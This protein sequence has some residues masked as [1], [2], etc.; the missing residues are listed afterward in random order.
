MLRVKFPIHRAGLVGGNR[1]QPS[2]C[3]SLLAGMPSYFTK[4]Q[5]VV[6]GSEMISISQTLFS[7]HEAN[8]YIQR[9]W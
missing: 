4:G 7:Q 1:A 9:N 8:G 6:P 3:A 2:F 5:K